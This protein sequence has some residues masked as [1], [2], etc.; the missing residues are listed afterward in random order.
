M[1]LFARHT[2]ASMLDVIHSDYV[3]T[4]RAK[5]LDEQRIVTRHMFRNALV[6]LMTLTGHCSA[7]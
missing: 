4:A 2:R 1:A 6:P 5:G 7:C 3:R